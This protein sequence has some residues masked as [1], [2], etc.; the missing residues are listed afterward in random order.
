MKTLSSIST[1]GVWSCPATTGDRPPPCAAL[2]FTAVD[3]RIAVLFGGFNGEQ[4]P[5][6][7]VFIINLSTVVLVCVCCVFICMWHV[8]AHLSSNCGVCVDVYVLV[9]VGAY[10]CGEYMSE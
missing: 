8:C 3:D 7:D 6:N 2:T 10:V 1:A 5:S 9:Y 4:R